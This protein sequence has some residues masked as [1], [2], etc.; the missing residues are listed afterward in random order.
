MHFIYENNS[1]NKVDG[2]RNLGVGDTD[3]YN[4]RNDTDFVIPSSRLCSFQTSFF[5]AS[6]KLWYELNNEVRSCLKV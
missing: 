3:R 2:H 6:L 1:L 5:P 4:L